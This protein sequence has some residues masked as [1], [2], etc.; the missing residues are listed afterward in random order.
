MDKEMPSP[1]A[2][3]V[4]SKEL[5]FPERGVLL[6][7]HPFVLPKDTR[8]LWRQHQAAGCSGSEPGALGTVLP[9]ADW[10]D[11]VGARGR[12]GQGS[13]ARVLQPFWWSQL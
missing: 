6:M 3:P 11:Q 10:R 4:G 1:Q 13:G 8:A 9:A 12:E 5:L 7:L 2:E